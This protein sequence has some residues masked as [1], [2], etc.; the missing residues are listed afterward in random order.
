MCLQL[1]KLSDMKLTTDVSEEFEKLRFCS[2]LGYIIIDYQK[3]A[4][5]T[6]SHTMSKQEWDTVQEIMLYLGWLDTGLDYVTN[7]QKR[8]IPKR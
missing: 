2:K 5:F 6:L 1:E 7:R 8:N 4:C 3:M